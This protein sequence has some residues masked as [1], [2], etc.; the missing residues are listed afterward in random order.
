MRRTHIDPDAKGYPYEVLDPW[1][2]KSGFYAELE[3]PL[4]R[5][6]SVVY[7]YDQLV[8]RGV[9]L[10]GS[11]AGMTPDSR[12]ERWTAGAMITPVSSFY[13]KLSYEFWMPSD[14]PEFH[15]G[16]LGVGGAF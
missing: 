11:A 5:W 15:S 13:V 14:H 10:P 9:P 8:R 4:G 3:H 16:H 1:V 6:T 7:R 12:L 2:D